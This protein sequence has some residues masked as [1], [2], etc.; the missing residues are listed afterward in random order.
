MDHVRFHGTLLELSKLWM[1]R[2]LKG[3]S[4]YGP[5]EYGCVADFDHS[6]REYALNLSHCFPLPRRS[7]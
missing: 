7:P 3:K 5:G 2:P 4:V 6:L 1:G